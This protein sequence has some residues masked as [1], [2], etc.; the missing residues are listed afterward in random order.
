MQGNARL[1]Y[2]SLNTCFHTS[3]PVYFY[4]LP[5][6][7]MVVLFTR[8][9]EE[10]IN[11]NSKE[12]VLAAHLDF[13]YDYESDV[14]LDFQD[15]EYN[16]EEFIE[17]ADKL[18]QRVMPLKTFGNFASNTNAQQFYNSNVSQMLYDLKPV[19]AVMIY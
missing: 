3:L 9:R 1:L 14:I 5:N 10:G 15:R 2:K 7:K 4:G 13:R 19:K 11:R 18:E 12:W 16:F 8:D 17:Y 6:K